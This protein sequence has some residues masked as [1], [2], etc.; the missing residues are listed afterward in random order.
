MITIS[1]A[2]IGIGQF[3]K[4][5]RL[6]YEF[7]FAPTLTRFAKVNHAE[8]C[9]IDFLRNIQM[10]AGHTCFTIKGIWN[11]IGWWEDEFWEIKSNWRSLSLIKILLTENWSKNNMGD[12]LL[13][14][15]EGK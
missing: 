1:I 7:E 3:P 2:C 8:S 9:M 15:C 13:F 5:K 10:K 14:N 12:F 4:I 6:I 11:L